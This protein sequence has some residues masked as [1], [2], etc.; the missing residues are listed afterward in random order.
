MRKFGDK[1]QVPLDLELEKIVRR[2]RKGNKERIEFEQKSME[3]V[4]GF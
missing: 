1:D 2:I 3:N 4:E